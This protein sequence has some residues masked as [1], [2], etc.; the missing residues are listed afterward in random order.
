MKKL[1]LLFIATALLGFYGYNLVFIPP[2][3]TGEKA[4]DIPAHKSLRT[5]ATILE[6]E[7]VIK[8]KWPLVFYAKLTGAARKLQSG[9]FMFKTFSSPKDALETLLHGT[10]VLHRVTIPEGSTVAEMAPWFEQATV[11]SATDFIAATRDIQ[12]LTAFGVPIDR[13]EGYLFPSTYLFP[14]NER[15]KKIFQVMID[16]LQKNILPE[17][18]QKA[19]RYG[20]NLHQWLTIASVIEKETGS[21]DE[22][23]LVSS[24][25]HNR[26]VK[27]MKLQSDPTVIY[28]IENYDGNI[29]KKDLITDH[30]YSTYTRK[31][32]PIGP[33]CSPGAAAIHA[34]V[35][36]ASTDFLYFVG[37]G[38]GAHVFTKTYEEHLKAVQKYQLGGVPAKKGIKR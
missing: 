38:Q 3:S 12:F 8:N 14:K 4:V 15:I 9:E 30:P 2:I 33:I 1:I 16:E 13:M 20:W 17:D 19:A 6:N 18:K 7:G 28:G 10:V 37:N 29:R 35:N 32:L 11:T 24:V 23:P 27:G 36:P 5:I 21:P 26:I 31:G 22:Y 25:F 34:A